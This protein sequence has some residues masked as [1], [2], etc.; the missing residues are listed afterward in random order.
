MEGVGGWSEQVAI[1]AQVVCAG[2][3]SFYGLV[4]EWGLRVA[5][6]GDPLVP[7]WTPIA[8]LAF[9]DT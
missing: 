8:V 7:V 3:P 5:E 9:A 2:A 4:D 6:S 1:S